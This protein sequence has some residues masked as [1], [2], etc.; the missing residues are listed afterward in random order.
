MIAAWSLLH[1][2]FT[3]AIAGWSTGAASTPAPSRVELD[4][5]FATMRSM[6]V[7]TLPQERAEQ[8]SRVRFDPHTRTVE[9]SLDG[10][11]EAWQQ[12]LLERATGSPQIGAVTWREKHSVLLWLRSMRVDAALVNPN[13]NGPTQLVLGEPRQRRNAR[14]A[15]FGDLCIASSPKGEHPVYK[16]ALRSSC[17]RELGREELHK[18]TSAPLDEV[19]S[20][21]RELLLA[22]LEDLDALSR[23]QLLENNPTARGFRAQVYLS[24]ALD[25]LERDELERALEL[26]ATM[27]SL[28][29]GEDVW[30]DP[31]DGLD[32]VVERLMQGVLVRRIEVLILDGKDKQAAETY[33]RHRRVLTTE[34]TPALLRKIAM[35]YRREGR[36]EVAAKVYQQ[37]LAL[38]S[39]DRRAFANERVAI[40]GEL[41]TTYIESGDAFRANALTLWAIEDGQQERI[42]PSFEV[43]T[44]WAHAG[45]TCPMP[46]VP[47][48]DADSDRRDVP[49]NPT[50]PCIE[51]IKPAASAYPDLFYSPQHRAQFVWG[52]STRGNSKIASR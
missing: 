32:A 50:N 45:R 47:A 11:S 39:K 15:W 48:P 44:R 34:Q 49:V 35:V 24:M 51:A 40:I 25:A 13:E 52:V 23:E 21:A 30:R 3:F 7:L 28:A 8:E 17:A 33:E 42:D 22:E 14:F 27:R 1:I 5:V 43:L 19:S 29:R 26:F 2:S 38:T 6:T 16:Q 41:A 10:T 20:R 4:D 9:I 36:P 12:E 46:E 18:L 31:E 37:A